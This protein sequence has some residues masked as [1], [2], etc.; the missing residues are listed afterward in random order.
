M[1][2]KFIPVLKSR[3]WIAVAAMI[4]GA[5]VIYGGLVQP[6]LTASRELAEVRDAKTEATR[7]LD[8]A[9]TD[10]DRCRRQI[11]EGEKL[12]EEIGGAPPPASAK[13]ALISQMTALARQSSVSIDQYSPL[14]TVDHDDH[15]AMYVQ[16]SGRGEFLAI[17]SYFNRIEAQIEFVDITHFTLTTLRDASAATCLVSWSCRIHGIPDDPAD[18]EHLASANAGRPGMT[19]GAPHGR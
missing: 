7:A 2:V 18:Q 13:D 5:G 16:F 12:L 6:S 4:L 11:A 10:F 8:R 19:E 1:K 9:R 15:L 17:Q 3:E 14:D